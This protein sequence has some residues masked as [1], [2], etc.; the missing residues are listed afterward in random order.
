[1]SMKHI[2]I[3]ALRLPPEDRARLALE[4]IESLENLAQS[5]LE[6][7]WLQESVRRARQIDAGTVDL[8]T[9]DVVA[10]EARALLKQ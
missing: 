3:G 2:E 1:M 6:G 10:R 4:L 9:G 7:L 5:E 8:I